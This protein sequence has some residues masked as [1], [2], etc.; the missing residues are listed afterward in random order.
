MLHI[1]YWWWKEYYKWI[2]LQANNKD[3]IYYKAWE[4]LLIIKS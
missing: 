4:D 3:I 2:D 1:Y